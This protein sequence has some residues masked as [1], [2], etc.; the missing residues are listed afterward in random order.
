MTADSGSPSLPARKFIVVSGCNGVGKSSVA[1]ALRDRLD[2]LVFHYPP[3]FVQF[4]ERASLDTAVAE[5]PRLL[6]YL[7]A[8]LHLSD[9]VRQQL[10]RSHV[11]CDRYVES[12]VSLLIAES[13]FLEGDVDRI[14]GPFQ[15]Y[16]CVPDLT[17]L[18]TAGYEAAC[19]RIRERLPA[20]CT[21]VEQLVLASPDF[22][23]RREIA[24]RT[25]AAKLGP[26]LELDTTNLSQTAMCHSAWALLAETLGPGW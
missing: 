14:C 21:R 13:A 1:Q 11:I 8:A 22:F 23:R 10:T 7:G 18:L 15:P 20:R 6:Y 3:E 2:A 12:P 17:L 24:L 26:V 9:L 5:L 19:H 4:R 16:L 25:Q